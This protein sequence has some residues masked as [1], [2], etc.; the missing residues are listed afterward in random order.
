MKLI[1][2]LLDEQQQTN[3][4]KSKAKRSKDND[5]LG[6]MQR[7]SDLEFSSGLSILPGLAFKPSRQIDRIRTNNGNFN[8]I[9]EVPIATLC[10]F[11]DKP[12][13]I[14]VFYEPVRLIMSSFFSIDSY[15][16]ILGLY[17]QSWCNL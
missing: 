7:T 4:L 9:V 2:A 8:C 5:E 12:E 11:Q 6:A 3:N 1:F 13:Q 15:G 17:N 16:I 10:F 14:A